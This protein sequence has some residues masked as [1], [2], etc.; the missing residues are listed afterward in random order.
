MPHKSLEWLLSRQTKTVQ[1]DPRFALLE[2]YLHQD[3]QLKGVKL[4]KREYRLMSKGVIQP[5]HVSNFIQTYRMPRHPFFL[6]FFELKQD[7]ALQKEIRKSSKKDFILKQLKELPGDVRNYL[8]ALAKIEQNINH[9]GKN[10]VWNRI[11]VP[12]TKKAAM[13][14][15]NF[16]LADWESLTERFGRQISVRYPGVP[17]DSWKK[18][19]SAFLLGYLPEPGLILPADP[20]E[21]RRQ[22]RRMSLECHPDTG[23]NEVI[24]RMLKDARDSLLES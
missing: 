7:E 3:L 10:P 11:M 14:Y 21:I 5:K 1:K 19:F 17:E 2:K 9:A 24:F 23:G 15:R 6:L 18:M 12:S 13:E 4:G 16:S 8:S 20:E 22:Y